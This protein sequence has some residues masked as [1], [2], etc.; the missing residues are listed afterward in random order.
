MGPGGDT[1]VG[2][3]DVMAKVADTG[4]AVSSVSG[5]YNAAGTA[6]ALRP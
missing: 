4:R 5:L 3:T 2:S 1:R 6:V